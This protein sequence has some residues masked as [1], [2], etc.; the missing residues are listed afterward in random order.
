MLIA[1]FNSPKSRDKPK[2]L[3]A[4][5]EIKQE[6]AYNTVFSHKNEILLGTVAYT[7]NPSTWEAETGAMLQV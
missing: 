1:L 6:Y 4:N 5:E 3:P 2:Y 7:Y